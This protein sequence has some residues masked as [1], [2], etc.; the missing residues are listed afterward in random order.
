MDPVITPFMRWLINWLEVEDPWEIVDIRVPHRRIAV[1]SMRT[2]SWYMEGESTVQISSVEELLEW[3]ERCEYESDMSL[4][5]ETDF[6]QHPRTFERL[7]RGDC[8]D[9]ALWA[10]RK[11]LEIGMDAS[12]V[13]GR[14]AGSANGHACV[15]FHDNG[16]QLILDPVVRDRDAVIRPLA[17]Y[18]SHFE[19]WFTV[20]RSLEAQ[21][22]EGYLLYMRDRLN[23]GES[24][25]RAW[26]NRH[27]TG[28]D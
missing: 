1:G 23:R 14:Y 9:H 3:L 13:I 25:L 24:F 28:Y 19:P 4:F 27:A 6:W 5:N 18:R 10:W 11:L 12:L 20:S 21:A 15:L 17:E 8:E 7:Q 26:R 2:F 22:R 16:A